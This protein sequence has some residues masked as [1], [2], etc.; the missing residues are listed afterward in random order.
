MQGGGSESLW[1][2]AAGR[3]SPGKRADRL[4]REPLEPVMH[5]SLSSSLLASVVGSLV[6]SALL[7]GVTTSLIA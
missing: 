5:R 4:Q 6:I 3:I 1:P 7:V 2:Q